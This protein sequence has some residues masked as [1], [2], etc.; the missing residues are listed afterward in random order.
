ML[1]L[2][3]RNKPQKPLTEA[4]LA[5]RLTATSYRCACCDRLWDA[6]HSVRLRPV[7]WADPPAVQ[8][9][10][11]L[12]QPGDVI[13]EGY[14]RRG[15]DLLVRA[16]FAIPVQGTEHHVFPQVW[17]NLSTGDFARFRSAQMRGDAD[18]LG[19]LSA[20]LYCRLPASNGP[21]LSKGVIVPVAG[22]AL[23][24]YWITDPKHPLYAAQHH[25]GL[26]P[27]QIVA[28]YEDLGAQ[29]LLVH[30]RA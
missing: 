29:A 15:R 22:G 30:L 16:E 18:R 12:D 3:R 25:G 2:F 27:T 10:S 24:L 6:A 9:D 28:L 13:T 1:R 19:D 7:G 8:A 11:A 14:A 5:Q 23:P 26:S 4:E 21:L 20:W 17:A